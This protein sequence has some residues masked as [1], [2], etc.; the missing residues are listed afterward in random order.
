MTLNTVNHLCG[1]RIEN[2]FLTSN[3][4]YY[5]SINN[6]IVFS[7]GKQSKVLKRNQ[8]SSMIVKISKKLCN[9]YIKYH[10]AYTRYLVL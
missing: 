5:S 10:V 4:L 7:F 1:F 6:S 9:V 8:L 2:I 3:L